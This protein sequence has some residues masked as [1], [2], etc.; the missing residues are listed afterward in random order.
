MNNLNLK[1]PVKR[2]PEAI[3]ATCCIP[4]KEDYS[5]DEDMFRKLIRLTLG[6]TKYVYLFGTAGEGYAIH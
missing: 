5:L 2:F 3:M 1:E 4:W 6:H